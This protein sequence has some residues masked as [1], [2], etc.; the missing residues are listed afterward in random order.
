MHQKGSYDKYTVI[1]SIAIRCK[2][3]LCIYI[4]VEDE[5]D[6]EFYV[7]DYI[8]EGREGGRDEQNRTGASVG[9]SILAGVTVGVLTG[10][11]GGVIAGLAVAGIGSASTMEADRRRKIKYTCSGCNMDKHSDTRY[12]CG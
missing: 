8:D 5:L 4:F 2:I 6:E 9:L 10:G 12:M 1:K 7:G 11:L 3:F